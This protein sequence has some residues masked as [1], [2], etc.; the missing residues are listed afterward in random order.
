MPSRVPSRP[1]TTP[2]RLWLAAIVGV[3]LVVVGLAATRAPGPRIFPDELIYMDAAAAVAGGDGLA[4]RG[5][6]Y[7][8]GPVYPVLVA[9]LVALTDRETAFALAQLLNALAIA[10]VAVP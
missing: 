9:P 4:V 1:R 6:E 5:G 8:Y 7:G 3:A 2:T 10:L